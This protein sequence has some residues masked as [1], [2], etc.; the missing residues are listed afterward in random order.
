MWLWWDPIHKENNPRSAP[1]SYR[2]YPTHALAE[3]MRMGFV[4]VGEARRKQPASSKIIVVIND[5]DDSISNKIVSQLVNSWHKYY[6]HL[7]ETYEFETNLNLPHDFITPDRPD[8]HI[9]ISYPIIL[10]LL[11]IKE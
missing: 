3:L 11:G 5:N 6:N 9:D 7:V 2:R 4:T 10:E 8:A 1:Y